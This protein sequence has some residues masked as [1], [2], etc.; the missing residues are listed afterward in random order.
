MSKE[1]SNIDNRNDEIDLLDLFRRIGKAFSNMFRSIGKGIIVS[2]VF[3]FR[4]WI[5]LTISII[6]AISLSFL[7]KIAA[8]SYY[9]SNMTIKSNTIPNAEMI[10]YIGKLHYF[11]LER[12]IPAIS[13]ALSIPLEK[14]KGIVDIKAYWIID[15]QNDGTP[16]YVDYNGN[17]NVYD[18]VNLRMQDRLE[19]RAKLSVPQDLSLLRNGIFSFIMNNPLYKQQNDLR[20]LQTNALL[21]RMNYDIEQLDSLQKIKYF[22]ET[23]SR[24]PEKNGQMIF[25]QE[26]KTQ[27]I[28]E[29]IQKLYTNKQPLEQQKDIYSDLITLISD[30]AV[31]VRPYTGLSYYGRTVVPLVLALTIIVLILLSNRKK[32]KDL[33]KNY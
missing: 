20:L 2:V 26:Q 25:L 6:F 28:Y 1:S 5:P 22:E 17:Y 32:I 11:C 14:A 10:S 3:L 30:F 31:P 4:R 8:P 24:L 9:L 33:L 18:T 27:L 12:N 16:D 19:I 29:E 21:D 7:L 23:K 15:R 13:E